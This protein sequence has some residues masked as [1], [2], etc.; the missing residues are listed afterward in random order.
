MS[1]DGSAPAPE[2]AD[3]D[4]GEWLVGSLADPLFDDTALAQIPERVKEA[5]L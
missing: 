1:V 3:A 2:A 5:L 4:G